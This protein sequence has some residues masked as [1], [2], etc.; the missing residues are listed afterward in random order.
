MSGHRHIQREDLAKTQGEE[1]PLKPRRKGS[2][3]TNTSDILISDFK[4]P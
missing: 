3:E 4:L 2:E 1:G